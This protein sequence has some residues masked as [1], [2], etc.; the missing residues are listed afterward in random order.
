MDWTCPTPPRPTTLAQLQA[1][2]R[3]EATNLK[4]ASAL[5]APRLINNVWLSA[6]ARDALHRTISG[7]CGASHTL[8]GIDFVVNQGHAFLGGAAFIPHMSQI[9]VAEMGERAQHWIGRCPAR[10]GTPFG[11]NWLAVPASPNHSRRLYLW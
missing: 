8:F 2:H 4:A 1:E 11:P 9:L 7:T 10:K 6:L 3:I 5:D